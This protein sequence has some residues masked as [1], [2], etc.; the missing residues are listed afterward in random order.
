MKDT[1]PDDVMAATTGQGVFVTAELISMLGPA[2]AIV[3]QQIRWLVLDAPSS[4]CEHDDHDGG[5]WGKI[6]RHDL[7]EW[8]G[9]PEGSVRR[10]VRELIDDYKLLAM[11]QDLGAV[12]DRSS[13]LAL[14][15]NLGKPCAQ[16]ARMVRADRADPHAREPRASTTYPKD[17][18][19]GEPQT[20]AD[21]LRQE[22]ARWELDPETNEV[23]GLTPQY[24]HGGPQEPEPDKGTNADGI[25]AARENLG[26]RP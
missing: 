13:W 9:I 26:R 4:V 1:Q 23:S 11:T 24:D 22:P 16:I 12:D 17:K 20:R 10:Y 3:Y 6:T 15:D 5:R 19:K 25:T 21:V 14:V 18:K 7:T 8:T 2:R